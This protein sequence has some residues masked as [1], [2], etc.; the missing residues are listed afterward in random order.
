LDFNAKPNVF[1]MW[2]PPRPNKDMPKLIPKYYHCIE[3]TRER[4][5]KAAVPCF[6]HYIKIYG[7]D[8]AMCLFGP[9]GH[10]IKYLVERVNAA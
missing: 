9:E 3:A 2:W 7:D 1:G 5:P 10:H 4:Q 6:V 8:V